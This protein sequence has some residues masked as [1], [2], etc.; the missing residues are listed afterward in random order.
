MNRLQ[1]QYKNEIKAKLQSELKLDNV[2]ELPNLKKIVVNAGIGEFRD[3][4]EALNSFLEELADITG[5]QPA[6]RK[7][8]KS[9]AGF[10]IRQNDVV[11]VSVTLRGEKMWAFLDKI[12]SIV[13]PRVRDFQGLSNKAFDKAGNYSIGIKEHVLFPEVNAN[14]TKGIRSLQV[15][16]VTSANDAE[17]GKAFLASL[18][19]PFRKDNK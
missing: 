8:R 2:M 4:K 1:E 7:A 6:L 13:L 3:N 19:L 18:G 9:I 12:I 16:L 17:S 10:K 15:T 14:K 5:Q 11:G